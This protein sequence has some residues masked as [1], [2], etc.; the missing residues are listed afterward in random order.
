M[1]RFKLRT[2]A[3]REKIEVIIEKGINNPHYPT[4]VK[5]LY[6]TLKDRQ[7][8]YAEQDPSFNVKYEDKR[9]LD[10]WIKLI[11]ESVQ[12]QNDIT[13]DEAEELQQVIYDMRNAINRANPSFQTGASLI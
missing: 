7:F 5:E 4:R 12:I 8:V 13:R 1:K 3:S 9:E 2:N 11:K 6:K 10:Q